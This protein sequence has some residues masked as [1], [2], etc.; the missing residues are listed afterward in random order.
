[1]GGCLPHGLVGRLLHQ[2][3]GEKALTGL[4]EGRTSAMQDRSAAS[5]VSSSVPGSLAQL[6]LSRPPTLPPAA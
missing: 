2:H 6:A 1:V 3:S 5:A 4:A